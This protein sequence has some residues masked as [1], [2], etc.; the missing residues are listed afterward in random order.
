MHAVTTV[1]YFATA[2]SY[3]HKNFIPLAPGCSS[4]FVTLRF[5]LMT[6]RHLRLLFS[7]ATGAVVI[8]LYF[9]RNLQMGP[10]S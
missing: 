2:V 6:Q 5:N 1:G 7:K 3:D 4:Q 10:I 9:L 8:T